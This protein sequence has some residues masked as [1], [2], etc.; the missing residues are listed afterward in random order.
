MI[1]SEITAAIERFAPLSLQ[2]GYDNAGL[3]T[4][5]PAM[6][7]TGA[8]VCLDASEEVLDEALAKGANLVVSHHPIVF[9]PLRSITGE[10]NVDRVVIQALKHDIALY[11]AHTNLDR[12]RHGMSDALAKKL[13]LRNVE[14]LD[15]EPSGHGFGAIGELEA[16]TG[17]LDFLRGVKKTLSVGSLRYSTPPKETVRRVA[18]VTGSGGD[19]LER[20]IEAGADVFLTADVRYDR[21]WAAEKRVLLAD[22][23]HYESEIV[24]IDLLYEILAKNFPT[25]ALHKSEAGRNPVEVLE[26]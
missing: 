3:I 4:G 14:I 19:G 16:P 22:I 23:G 5:R 7:I 2:E 17:A 10:S 21:F 26:E 25:F 6:E 15:P 18:L 1:L 13:G 9:R 11:A 24:A 12:A 8:V 20:A